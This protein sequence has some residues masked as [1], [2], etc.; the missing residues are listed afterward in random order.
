MTVYFEI[1]GGLPSALAIGATEMYFSQAGGGGR[2]GY[3]H[4]TSRRNIVMIDH[5]TV[6]GSFRAHLQRINAR[7]TESRNEPQGVTVHTISVPTV[8]EVKAMVA[9][10]E[11]QYQ[12]MLHRLVMEVL[13]EGEPRRRRFRRRR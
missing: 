8:A 12:A 7:F 13:L 10:A 9:E 4:P 11:K 2:V 5:P 1:T 3:S 6:V